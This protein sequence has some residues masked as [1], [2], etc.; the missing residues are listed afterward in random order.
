MNNKLK[1]IYWFWISRLWWARNICY[2]IWEAQLFHLTSIFSLYRVELHRQYSLPINAHYFVIINIFFISYISL[3][4]ISTA[5]AYKMMSS[6]ENLSASLALCAGNSP[7][8]GEFPAQRPV[9]RSFDGFFIVPPKNGW[10]NNREAEVRRYRAHYDVI[11]MNC[12][13]TCRIWM[14]AENPHRYLSKAQMYLKYKINGIHN[15][16]KTLSR[17]CINLLH[18]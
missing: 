12:G 18:S 15:I 4:I 7:D 2:T 9:T 1:K 5:K 17:V 3:Y 6:N 8:T 14:W 10:V 11:V 13:D 16:S